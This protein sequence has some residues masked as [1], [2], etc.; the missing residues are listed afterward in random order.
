ML[1]AFTNRLPY[2][3][4][5]LSPFFSCTCE[6]N[7]PRQTCS[8]VVPQ[9]G[10]PGFIL[11]FVTLLHFHVKVSVTNPSLSHTHTHTHSLSH[12]PPP[13][14]L[15]LSLS[16]SLRIYGDKAD[17]IIESLRQTA[18]RGHYG[19]VLK[20]YPGSTKFSCLFFQLACMFCILD[21]HLTGDFHVP[22]PT[23]NTHEDFGLEG[24]RKAHYVAY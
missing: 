6:Y 17:E 2:F 13:P 5:L 15:S 12:C 21:I 10:V 24:K 23:G 4:C 7:N 3:P 18:E 9:L 16:L 11:M 20:R 14:P 19:F 22:V 8:P 1:S